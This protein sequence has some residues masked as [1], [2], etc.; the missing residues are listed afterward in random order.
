MVSLDDPQSALPN[1]GFLGTGWGFPPRFIPRAMVGGQVAM[2]SA[3][4]DIAESL[5]ILFNTVR[6]ERP[7]AP[8]YG[9]SLQ[10]QLFEPLTT[11]GKTLLEDRIRI[12]V[13]LYEPRILLLGLAVDVRRQN[14]GELQV[15]LH[16]QIRATNSR[17]NQV[18]PYYR[19][20]GNQ[21]R[22]ALGVGP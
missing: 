10:P 22:A 13:L 21:G 12:G 20:D 15:Q 3:E 6:G 17:Y 9:L 1:A 11:T 14:E 5:Q 19:H 8:D 2:A 16:Y 4:Q 7:F 18:F